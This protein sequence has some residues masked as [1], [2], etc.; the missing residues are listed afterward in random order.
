VADPA[1]SGRVTPAGR[2]VELRG[3]DVSATAEFLDEPNPRLGARTTT[4][5]SLQL[6][7]K[8]RVNQA[9][10]REAPAA[11]PTVTAT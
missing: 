5:T 9:P 6:H 8:R 7:A 1:V 11:T 2:D 4:R 3:V 10:E